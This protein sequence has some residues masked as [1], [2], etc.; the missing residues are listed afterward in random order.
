MAEQMQGVLPAPAIQS[1]VPAEMAVIAPAPVDPSAAP[2]A[3]TIQPA[4]SVPPDSVT[5]TLYIQ[6][7]NERVK[8]D[9]MRSR[10]KS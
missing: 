9:G 8:L 6:N 5:E 10:I 4:A 1:S 2:V 3:A 7:L